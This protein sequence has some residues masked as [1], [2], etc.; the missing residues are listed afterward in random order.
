MTPGEKLI[1]KAK[2]NEAFTPSASIN[3]SDLFAGRPKQIDRVVQAVFQR[4]QHAIIFG[5]RGVGKTSL[6][7]II[8]DLLILAGKSEFQVAKHTCG[9]DVSFAGIWRA[10]FKQLTITPQHTDQLTMDA[11]L[12]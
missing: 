9:A 10:I 6:A 12:P 2:I 4:G 11:L 8:Y 5:E 7:N 1:L 3:N